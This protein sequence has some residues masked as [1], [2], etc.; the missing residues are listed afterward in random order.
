M[1]NHVHDLYK[2]RDKRNHFVCR[3]CGREWVQ[4]P[5]SD[6]FCAEMPT[7]KWSNKPAEL[8][9]TTKWSQDGYKVNGDAKHSGFVM[10][11]DFR[12]MYKLYDVSQVHE[13]PKKKVKSE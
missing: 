3:L 8:K 6:N 10:S 12:T 13:K 2:D 5:D 7:Y 4:K 1:S 11:G 9:T